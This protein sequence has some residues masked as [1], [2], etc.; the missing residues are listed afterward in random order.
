MCAGLTPRWQRLPLVLQSRRVVLAN[1]PASL[2]MNRSPRGGDDTYL[3][4]RADDRV[5]VPGTGR[6]P[7]GSV[8]LGNGASVISA[9]PQW[10]EH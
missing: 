1:R 2:V 3:R 4:R 5:H 6:G 9:D 8:G 7:A 10:S